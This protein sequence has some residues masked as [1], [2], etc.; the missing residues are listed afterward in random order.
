MSNRNSP[1]WLDPN[2]SVLREDTPSDDAGDTTPDA[3]GNVT[4]PLEAYSDQ[5]D[6]ADRMTKQFRV[7]VLPTFRLLGVSLVDTLLTNPL[8]AS[9]HQ[10][11]L[12]PSIEALSVPTSSVLR[13]ESTGNTPRPTRFLALNPQPLLTDG[14]DEY[15]PVPVNVWYAVVCR[16]AS[17]S[18][19]WA[20]FGEF[21]GLGVL[22]VRLS[23]LK[24]AAN[25]LFEA[26]LYFK[27][28]S[29]RDRVFHH[30]LEEIG[31]RNLNSV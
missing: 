3:T 23:R 1:S 26:H 22:G 14:I 10:A 2:S 7:I 25:C 18:S 13:L 11:I 8:S 16:P 6:Q 12:F 30:L 28:M 31:P 20:W 5:M 24:R 9:R 29:L 15:A 4:Q 21:E 27:S 19:E 17:K